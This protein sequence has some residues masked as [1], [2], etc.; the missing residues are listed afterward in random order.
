MVVS[1]WLLVVSWAKDLTPGPSP[2]ERGDGVGRGKNLVYTYIIYLYLGSK[3]Q[4]VVA[5]RHIINGTGETRLRQR[6][7]KI[8]DFTKY[9]MYEFTN[10]EVWVIGKKR[11]VV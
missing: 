7:V 5:R 2:K 6:G 3:K 1:C 4:C 8:W 10:S 9:E 11:K